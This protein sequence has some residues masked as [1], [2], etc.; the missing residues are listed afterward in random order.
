MLSG[1]CSTKNSWRSWGTEAQ[2]LGHGSGET[3]FGKAWRGRPGG[4]EHWQNL[5]P[6]SNIYPFVPSCS[7]ARAYALLL[8]Y[9][10]VLTWLPQ[11]PVREW[12]LGDL[13]S[14]LSVA[15]MQLPQGEPPL[16]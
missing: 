15:I 2:Q 4:W 10:P 14:G 3:G 13:L 16:T 11:Y 9:L 7:R 5:A 8:Q 12:L 6:I 1:L